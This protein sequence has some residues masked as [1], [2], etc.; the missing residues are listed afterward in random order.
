MCTAHVLIRF[1]HLVDRS[2]VCKAKE[3]PH[4]RINNN[5]CTLHVYCAYLA[6]KSKTPAKLSDNNLKQS[7][8]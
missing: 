4:I 2:F 7:S 1:C 5:V 6:K 8:F 3:G